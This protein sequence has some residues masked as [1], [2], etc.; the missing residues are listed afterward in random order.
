MPSGNSTPLG[1]NVWASTGIWL[2]VINRSDGRVVVIFDEVICE[3][4]S[5]D[6]LSSGQP[7]NSILLAA[8]VAGA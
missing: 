2:A 1:P 6:D 4:A 7:A 5:E 8:G 3:Y